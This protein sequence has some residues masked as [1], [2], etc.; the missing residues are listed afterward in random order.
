MASAKNREAAPA[1][2][3]KPIL[4]VSYEEPKTELHNIE[5]PGLRLATVSRL[6][7]HSGAHVTDEY[8]DKFFDHVC[9]GSTVRVNVAL[10]ENIMPTVVQ[11]FES[12][13][14]W[15]AENPDAC[16]MKFVAGIES[17]KPFRLS[18]LSKE[19]QKEVDKEEARLPEK[20]RQELYRH[21]ARA[22]MIHLDDHITIAVIA[23]HRALIHLTKRKEQASKFR[24][25]HR[26]LN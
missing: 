2:Q 26:V 9:K 7:C 3:Q 1:V 20:T 4:F 22:R 24:L 12:A 13:E 8:P 18:Q 19:E 10:M 25:N 14:I 6:L 23:V 5:D 15:N 17:E 11:A 21:R 16:L